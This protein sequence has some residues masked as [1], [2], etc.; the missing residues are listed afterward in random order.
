MHH[1]NS[2][3][4]S[5]L[6]RRHSGSAYG[7]RALGPYRSRSRLVTILLAHG[8]HRFPT[9]CSTPQ[10]RHER[11]NLRGT[12]ELWEWE[13]SRHYEAQR[14]SHALALCIPYLVE[15]LIRL[16]AQHAL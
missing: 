1:G 16:T 10:L 8:W 7:L 2:A 13:H 4:I 9:R 5:R 6:S 11:A 3:R 14:L 12:R 15:Y